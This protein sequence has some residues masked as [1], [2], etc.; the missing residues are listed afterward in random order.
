M[1]TRIFTF[2][3]SLMCSLSLFSQDTKKINNQS[4]MLNG[5]TNYYGATS[6]SIG[7]G[8]GFKTNLS[9]RKKYELTIISLSSANM[10]VNNT[11]GSGFAFEINTRNYWDKEKKGFYNQSALAHGEIDF[12]KYDGQKVKYSYWSLINYGL[13]YDFKLSNEL[14][15]DLNAAIFW[16]WNKGYTD[17][18]NPFQNRIG[19]NLVYNFK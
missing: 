9:N 7:I 18:V 1:K 4:F 3:L 6:S 19:F 10:K 12:T 8:Y 2:I 5:T 11:L 16:H 15:F 13:G 14:S 17:N